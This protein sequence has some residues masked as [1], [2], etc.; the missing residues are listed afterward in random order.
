MGLELPRRFWCSPTNSGARSGSLRRTSWIT[1][2]SRRIRRRA[3]VL[4]PSFPTRSHEA[5][6]GRHGTGLGLAVSY[7][8]ASAHR[9]RMTVAS[10]PCEGA[11]FLVVL[12]RGRCGA[13]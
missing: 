1:G 12:P 8:I 9:G 11:V 13:G 10:V 2:R 6:P 3:D 5:D 4:E 7:G